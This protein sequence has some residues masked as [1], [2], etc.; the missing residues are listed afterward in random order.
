MNI[1][2]PQADFLGT[3]MKKPIT[4]Y[5]SDVKVAGNLRAAGLIREAGKSIGHSTLF[6]PT[7]AGIAA[8]QEFRTKRYAARGCVAYLEDMQ[9]VDEHLCERQNVRDA[10][11]Y[12]KPAQIAAAA[13][14]ESVPMWARL[15]YADATPAT[16]EGVVAHRYMNAS[17]NLAQYAADLIDRQ[18][19]TVDFYLDKM[20]D[21][22]VFRWTSD[23]DHK[24]G[25]DPWRYYADLPIDAEDVK[26]RG[27]RL[28]VQRRNMP[29]AA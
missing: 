29:A 18:E 16:P 10:M 9:E 17:D 14:D 13:A 4:A 26:A 22:P 3:A 15:M 21:E 27:W 1:T 28:F 24:C 7:E 25:L 19:V 6:V 12:M 23:E 11:R 8:L 2:K 20:C 5:A